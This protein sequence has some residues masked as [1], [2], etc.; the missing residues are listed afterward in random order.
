[1]VW[2][3]ICNREDELSAP[4]GISLYIPYDCVFSVLRFRKGFSHS[5]VCD[6]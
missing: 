3:E 4:G 1:M 2:L 5:L 6:E